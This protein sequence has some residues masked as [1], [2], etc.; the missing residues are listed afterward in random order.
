MTPLHF[1]YPVSVAILYYGDGSSKDDVDT[2]ETL[3]NLTEALEKR[4]HV[5]R[6]MKV[7]KKNW[8]KAVRIPGEIVFNLVEDPGWILYNKV[9]ELLERLG[10]AQ[11]GQNM[12]T[13]K[14]G[15]KKAWMKRRMRRLGISTPEFRI[16]NRRSRVTQVRG[17]E[18]P[19]FVK[20][21]GQH[22]GIG[23]SQDSV[24]IDE[25]EL[26]ERVKYLFKYFPGEVIAEQF[27]DGREIHVTVL[28]NGKHL[29][30]LP[31][32]EL[33]F[34]GEY[35]DNWEIYTFEAK[36]NDES[37]EYWSV[38]VISPI[39]MTKQLGNRIEKLVKK[40]FRAFSCKDIARFDLR[41]DK[42]DKPYIVDININPSLAKQETDATWKSAVA[43][44]WSYED[45]VETI[46]GITYKRYYGKMPERIRDRQ[47]LLTA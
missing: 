11:V 38:P 43:L 7:N 41:V 18:Y 34:V 45:L 24:V 20:P 1:D 4:G 9:G 44:E 33:V 32:A 47:L 37:W 5:V 30:T 13:L 14:Y 36:W 40:A 3:A 39:K 16:F 15:C 23:I 8:R 35:A 27:V 22:A 10:R 6:S 17:L 12:K 46:V 31:Y 26:S 25:D 42:N 19:L 2:V 29:V 21:S 28:G